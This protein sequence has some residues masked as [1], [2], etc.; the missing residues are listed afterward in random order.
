MKLTVLQRG[1]IKNPR[2]EERARFFASI[3]MSTRMSNT[4][5]VRIEMRSTTLVDGNSAQ[6]THAA[7]GS[8]A[9]KHFVIKIDRDA[10][11]NEQI[12]FLAHEMKHVEQVA[13]GRYQTR[14]WA[15]DRQMHARWNGTE[16]GTLSSL[17]YWTRPWE[18]EAREF[19][20]Q[21]TPV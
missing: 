15:S 8:K 19:Q 9:S 17:P 16:M 11:F 5:H 18:V 13:T 1:G 4:L 14:V 10:P 7:N 21:H 2:I 12:G 6:V 20:K 3:L